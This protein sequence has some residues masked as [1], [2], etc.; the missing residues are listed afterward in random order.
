MRLG[1]LWLN[2]LW[3]A[4]ELAQG[5]RDGLE[6]WT[7]LVA[8]ACARSL[9]EGSAY[10]AIELPEVFRLWDSVKSEG[11]PRADAVNT[12]L[13]EL[14]KRTMTAHYSTKLLQ[15]KKRKGEEK[16]F[17]ESRSAQTY[18]E[19]LGRRDKDSHADA[20]YAFLCDA[21][22]P[23]FGSAMTYCTLFETDVLQSHRVERY[24]RRPLPHILSADNTF[25]PYIAEAVAEAIIL[26]ARLLNRDLPALRWLVDDVYLTAELQPPP[27][28]LI[29]PWTINKPERNSLCP[30]GS[31]RKFKRCV[32]R[33]GLRG[34]LP[35]GN[36]SD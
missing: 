6:R 30:C 16:S 25:P 20:I 24:Y 4:A 10:L 3:R 21:I 14:L 17:L 23:S 9:L 1:A 26:A 18:I 27:D 13:S 12:F 5:A 32:H 2:H 29:F 8:A 31:G 36:S 35:A 33:W 34:T 19:K 7:I 11:H 22:H 15:D 28:E